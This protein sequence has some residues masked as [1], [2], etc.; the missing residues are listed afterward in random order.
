MQVTVWI[1]QLRKWVFQLPKW[2]DRFSH[3]SFSSDGFWPA[4]AGFGSRVDF[5]LLVSGHRHAE[6]P[7]LAPCHVA[8]A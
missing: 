2:T 3:V 7:C 8:H 5:V 1:S 4:T 6:F